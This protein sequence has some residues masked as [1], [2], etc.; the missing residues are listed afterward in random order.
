MT[1]LTHELRDR[2]S[3]RPQAPVPQ[4]RLWRALAE[5]S[6]RERVTRGADVFGEASLGLL[7]RWRSKRLPWSAADRVMGMA[8][9]TMAHSDAAFDT[10]VERVREAFI[11]SQ[12]DMALVERAFA[13]GYE[14]IR[15][16][17]GLSLHRV[18]VVSGLLLYRGACV[19]LATGEGK[20]VTAILPAAVRGWQGRGVH[21]V[22]V[23]DYLAQ[24]DA[25]TTA[26]AYRRLGVRVGSVQDESTPADRLEAYSRDVTY[27]SDKQVI[28][29]HLRDRMASPIAPRLAGLLLEQAGGRVSHAG[30]ASRVVQRGLACAIVDEADSVLIDEAITPA[31]LSQATIASDAAHDHIRAAST[32]ARELHED[33]DYEVDRRLQRVRLTDA[34]RKRAESMADRL[35]AFWAGPRRREELLVQAITARELYILGSD[36]VITDGKVHIVD[37]STGRVLPGRQWQL[38]LHQAVESKEGVDITPQTTTSARSSYQAFFTRYAQLSGMTGT[39]REVAGE[40]WRWYRLVVTRVPTHKPVRRV[41]RADRVFAT[42]AQRTAAVVARVAELARAGRP[43]LVGARTVSA[44]ESLGVQLRDAGIS[45]QVLNATRESDE[46]GIVAAAGQQGAVTVATPMAGRGTDIALDQKSRE[47]GGLAVVA[48]SRHDENRVDRQFFGRAGRQGDPGSAEC[49]LALDDE[50]FSRHGFR[51]LVALARRSPPGVRDALGRLARRLAQRSASGAWAS[52]RAETAR[53]EAW[54]EMAMPVVTR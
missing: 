46:A 52:S 11:A 37:R 38:G 24:R 41:H 8:K 6:S 32:M 40:M 14:A 22:T 23:N 1:T 36:Y 30:W 21:V 49:F 15:R 43:V 53:A 27:A 5:R 25:E 12:S 54:Q 18:Q 42:E 7:A 51:P 2:L 29:D 20:T 33:S 48:T 10:E 47:A 19:E 45:C 44:S 16:E 28:F 3:G 50:L 13:L 39:A 17:L 26:P 31:I 4:P 34:G 35:P 9:D